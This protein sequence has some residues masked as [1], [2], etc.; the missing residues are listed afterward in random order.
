[1]SW[2]ERL[3]RTLSETVGV[4][5][6][7]DCGAGVHSDISTSISESDSEILRE[8]LYKQNIS[9]SVVIHRLTVIIR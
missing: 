9:S 4:G 6:D 8:M 2:V 7:G 1:M 5:E 3:G